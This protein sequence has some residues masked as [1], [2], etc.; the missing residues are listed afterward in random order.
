MNMENYTLSYYKND[1]PYFTLS[2]FEIDEENAP[3]T[4]SEGV[5]I[6]GFQG[7]K[8]EMDNFKLLNWK[9]DGIGYSVILDHPDLSFEEV[10]VLLEEMKLAE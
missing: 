7:E 5:N 2:F 9:E 1:L 8:M 3:F 4:G 6:R 10:L